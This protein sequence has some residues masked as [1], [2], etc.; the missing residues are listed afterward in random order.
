MRQIGWARGANS[1]LAGGTGGAGGRAGAR[2]GSRITL[3][4]SGGLEAP[5]LRALDR[6]IRSGRTVSVLR[7]YLSHLDPDSSRPYHG[8]VAR[9]LF[10]DAVQHGGGQIFA[11]GNGD[12]VLVAGAEPVA[13]LGSVLLRLFRT[14]SQAELPLLGAWCLPRD[15]AAIRTEFTCIP[16]KKGS[17]EDTPPPLGALAAISASLASAPHG[18]LVRR[19]TAVRIQHGHLVTLFDE[20]ALSF[21]ALE[22]HAGIKM[23]ASADPYLFRYISGQLDQRMLGALAETDLS[24]SPALHINLP[25]ASVGSAGFTALRSAARSARVL[26]GVVLPFVEAV[27]DMRRFGE[28]RC[29]LQAEGCTVTLDGIDQHVLLHCDPAALKPDLLKLEWSPLIPALAARDERRLGRALRAI[30]ANRIVLCRAETEASLIWGLSQGISCFQGRHVDAMLA[31]DRIRT[32]KFSGGCSLGQ[33]ISRAAATDEAGRHGCHDTALL[34]G[35][36]HRHPDR[37]HQE[38]T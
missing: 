8:R 26:L 30:G 22:A 27:A 20:L 33:C 13:S 28:L 5:V 38:L 16:E 9:C 7:L 1:M 25:L 18:E 17:M 23:P 4:A 29:H 21:P 12:L 34:G 36:L 32:C 6:I 24:H 19:Q 10:D 2:G 31:A 35:A 3:A 15:E 37:S 11:F 14:E